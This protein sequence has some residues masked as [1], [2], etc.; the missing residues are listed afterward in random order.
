MSTVFIQS[1]WIACV[2]IYICAGQVRVKFSWSLS[3]YYDLSLSQ[4]LR[5]MRQKPHVFPLKQQK[6]G[7]SHLRFISAH[8]HRPT[9][10]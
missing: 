9:H 8:I 7:E 3:K 5:M 4:P 2:N 1:V 10:T 6:W